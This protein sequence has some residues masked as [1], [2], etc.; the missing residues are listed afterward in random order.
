MCSSNSLVNSVEICL[1]R[2][3]ASQ[4]AGRGYLEWASAVRGD[5]CQVLDS[6]HRRGFH[7]AWGRPSDVLQNLPM[8][9]HW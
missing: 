5:C 3:S 1:Y 4:I 9:L 6:L 8:S 2:L 7:V